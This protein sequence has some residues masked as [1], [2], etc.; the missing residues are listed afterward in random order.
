MYLACTFQNKGII[1]EKKKSPAVSF[2]KKKDKDIIIKSRPCF[3]KKEAP[4]W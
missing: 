3:T 2:W 4:H 1:P